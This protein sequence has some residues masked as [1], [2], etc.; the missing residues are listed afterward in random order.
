MHILNLYQEV[1]DE[2][3][4]L[5]AEVERLGSALQTS[6]AERNMVRASEAEIG[7]RIA[8]LEEA[9][10]SLLEQNQDLAARLTT[11]QIRRL[12]SEKLLL[13]TQIAWHRDRA[14]MREGTTQE[15]GVT[16]MVKK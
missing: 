6:E 15:G 16:A 3:D 2:R 9:K 4:S 5:L 1:L 12:E 14:V 7:T 13:E 8:A 10:R 11:A